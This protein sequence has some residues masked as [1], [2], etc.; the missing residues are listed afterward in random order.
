MVGNSPGNIFG[1]GYAT[2]V[3]EPY[4]WIKYH[5]NPVLT[6]GEAGTWDDSRV[7]F[8]TVTFDGTLFHMLYIGWGS[9]EIYGFGYASSKDGIVWEKYSGNPVFR[10]GPEG[11]PDENAFGYPYI[12]YH[13]A[14]FHMWY[15]ARDNE[16]NRTI[17]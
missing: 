17:C 4:L 14:I 11:S 13:K 3:W 9:P 5:Q 10:L 16:Y 12:L 7:L 15:W 6:C 2:S 1:F 8:P